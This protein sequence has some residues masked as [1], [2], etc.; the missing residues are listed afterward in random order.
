M[1]TTLSCTRASIPR[2]TI[3]VTRCRR[4]TS[5]EA[6]AVVPAQPPIIST[7]PYK[8]N[9]EP[10]G[11]KV[12]RQLYPHLYI[13]ED[14][15]ENSG[16][17]IQ[18]VR[19][20]TME[21]KRISDKWRPTMKQAGVQPNISTYTISRRQPRHFMAATNSIDTSAPHQ[22]ITTANNLPQALAT[23]SPSSAPKPPTS[24]KPAPNPSRP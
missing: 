14:G 13:G 7:Q 6:V 12:H 19:P 2:F 20:R 21:R 22:K 5:T 4:F 18:R 10:L 23:A 8:H 15:T 16:Q 24:R 3:K 1:S 9:G 11:A 17:G